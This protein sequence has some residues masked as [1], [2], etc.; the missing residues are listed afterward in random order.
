MRR[1]VESINVKVDEDISRI[2]NLEARYESNQ[3]IDREDEKTGENEVQNDTKVA[4]A[5]NPK[6]P[7]YLQ[8]NHSKK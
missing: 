8:K 6:T 4:L 1:I 5:T 7:R 3:S 2:T